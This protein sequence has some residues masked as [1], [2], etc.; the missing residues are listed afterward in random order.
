MSELI[1]DTNLE[2]S[3]TNG[4]QQMSKEDV[5]ID[6]KEEASKED[7]KVNKPTQ[8]K[9]KVDDLIDDISNDLQVGFDS[10]ISKQLKVDE[11]DDKIKISTGIDLFDAVLGG[12]IPL[13]SFTVFVGNPGGGKSTLAT[14]VIANVQEQYPGKN[15]CLYL[16]SEQSMTS[17]RLSQLGV[18][19]PKL[20]PKVG[21]TIEKVFEIIEAVC[22]YK[23]ENKIVDTPT[24]IV[25][26]S[27]ANTPT[28]KELE[29]DDVNSV[30]G[31]KARILSL[32]LPKIIN[33]L[34]EYN[35]A[36]IAINQLRDK[37]QMGMFQT[38]PDLKYLDG[39]KDMPGGHAVK[40][41]A[42]H[43]INVRHKSDLKEEQY[44]YNGAR[45]L[46]KMVKNKFFLSGVQIEMALDFIHGFDNFWTNYIF[47]ADNKYIKTGAWN[48]LDNYQDKKFRTKE[49]K[50]LYMSDEGFRTAFNE[51]VKV[52]IEEQILSKYK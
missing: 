18:N 36:L 46:L 23:E 39:E 44:G 37:L 47:L 8:Q 30:I 26:D 31:L 28:Q 32:T 20:K 16:D 43:L 38:A 42:S 12:G 11:L 22:M 24:V 35:I 29:V 48:A 4:E 5:K 17:V 49:A 3:T 1:F 27:I 51:L 6:K 45:I 25:W 33:R 52:A 2:N 34:R 9:K 40:F 50:D 10:F 13:G 19:K 21:V 15:L 41:N 14:K 7:V